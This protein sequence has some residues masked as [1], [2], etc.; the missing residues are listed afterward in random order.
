M[1]QVCNLGPWRFVS[2]A[3]R[4]R[5][6]KGRGERRP[7]RIGGTG[8]GAVV[9]PWE[10]GL[11]LTAGRDKS[12]RTPSVGAATSQSATPR[13]KGRIIGKPHA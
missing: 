3:R 10:S 2:P 12:H 6:R 9:C 8:R 5:T 4:A 1:A 7:A 11:S 13:K